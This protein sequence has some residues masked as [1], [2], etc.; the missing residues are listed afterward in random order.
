MHDQ[1]LRLIAG[2]ISGNCM[3]SEAFHTML[4]KACC[5]PGETVQQNSMRF[6]LG[7]E[8]ISVLNGKEIP[9]RLMKA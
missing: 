8:I 2:H 5:S 7:N 3:K 9:W 1:K 4:S 6:I